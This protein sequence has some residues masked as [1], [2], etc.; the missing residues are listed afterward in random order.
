MN[1]NIAGAFIGIAWLALVGVLALIVRITVKWTQLATRL[2]SIAYQIGQLVTNDAA[3][4]Q[5][6]DERLLW[7]ERNR[8]A[9]IDRAAWSS[10]PPAH[11]WERR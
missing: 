8:E 10:P 5:R 11:P 6:F 2:D 4:H 3:A 9:T 7:L 1:A